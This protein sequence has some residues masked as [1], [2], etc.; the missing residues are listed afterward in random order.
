MPT[1]STTSSIPSSCP[2]ADSANLSATV[3][4]VASHRRVHRCR[5]A[6]SASGDLRRYRQVRQT[7]SHVQFAPAQSKKQRRGNTKHSDVYV[8]VPAYSGLWG[9]KEWIDIGAQGQKSFCD[10]WSLRFAAAIADGRRRELFVAIAGF[11]RPQ[12]T[13]SLFAPM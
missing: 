13:P 7:A 8:A 6:R 9:V 11:A 2:S 5:S 4:R 3:R 12:A 10:F 1:S